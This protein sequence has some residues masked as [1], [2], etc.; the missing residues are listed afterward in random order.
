[1]A[2]KKPQVFLSY[3]HED[4]KQV[5]RLYDDLTACGVNVWFD[6]ED[7]QSGMRWKRAIEKVIPKSRFFL[8]CLSQAALRKLGDAPGFQDE[9]LQQAYEI[10]R[11]QEEQHFAI[12]PVR[13]EECDRGDARLSVWQQV[14]L[15]PDWNSAVNDLAVSLGGDSVGGVADQEAL[16]E[17]TQEQQL[18]TGLLGKASAFYYAGDYER[19]LK[20]VEA[21]IAISENPEA[22]SN[23][24]VALTE[25]GQHEAAL[26]AFD[27]AIAMQ[28]DLDGAWNNKGL[29]L[30]ELGRHKEA[31]EVLEQAIALQPEDADSW[32]NKGVALYHLERYEEALRAYEMALAFEPKSAM[33]W[34]NMGAALGR[35]DRHEEALKACDHAIALQ[36]EYAKAW[37]NKGVVLEELGRDTEASGAFEEAERLEQGS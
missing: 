33:T 26:K 2:E 34:A 24:G 15:F 31:L 12:I 23:K 13:L 37:C 11:E 20:T 29:T 21:I 7:L 14:D 9:E 8:I 36:P 28:A 10:A 27:Q 19:M 18:I 30:N 4:L 32:N 3:A 6:K 5:R 22:W 16:D 1:M 25:L 17:Q 35:L